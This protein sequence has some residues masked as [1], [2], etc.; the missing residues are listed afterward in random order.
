MDISNSLVRDIMDFKPIDYPVNIEQLNV[1][2]MRNLGRLIIDWRKNKVFELISNQEDTHL[3]EKAEQFR[4]MKEEFN[5]SGEY[6]DEDKA[7]VEFN[8]TCASENV[9]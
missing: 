8:F 3:S 5:T 7:Y 6:D 9:G 4:M 2:G 1:K